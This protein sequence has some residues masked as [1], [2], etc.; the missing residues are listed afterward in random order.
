MFDRSTI[1]RATARF[2]L[3]H[4]LRLY[5]LRLYGVLITLSLL[6]AVA[7]VATGMP[8]PADHAPHGSLT[9]APSATWYTATVPVREGTWLLRSAVPAEATC[10]LWL[11]WS[12]DGDSVTAAL[13][14]SESGPF[15]QFVELRYPAELTYRCDRPL[16]GIA[17]E[18]MTGVLIQ[19]TVQRPQLP[20]NLVASVLMLAIMVAAGSLLLSLLSYTPR[21]D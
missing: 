16:P 2:T 10:H 9:A 17:V 8:L 13:S 11:E 6:G 14:L 5:D 21:N 19:T 18:D 7:G 3:P 1:G 15:A 20:L 4:G 12:R